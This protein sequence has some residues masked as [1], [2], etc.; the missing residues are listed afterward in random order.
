MALVGI[1]CT[2]WLTW[3]PKRCGSPSP[4]RCVPA[5]VSRAAPNGCSLTRRTRSLLIR[6]AMASCS[7]RVAPLLGPEVRVIGHDR[8]IHEDRLQFR[9][10]RPGAI[11][12]GRAPPKAASA[13]SQGLAAQATVGD[14]SFI[15]FHRRS[16]LWANCRCGEQCSIAEDRRAWHPCRTETTGILRTVHCRNSL[17]SGLAATRQQHIGGI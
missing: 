16:A 5:P 14:E 1:G 10:N 12:N 3:P 9:Q 2:K 4:S 15:G 17:S 8:C 11:E 7:P 13:W 6:S